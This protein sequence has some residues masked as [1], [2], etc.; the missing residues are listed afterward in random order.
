MQLADK[1]HPVA[2]PAVDHQGNIYVTFSGP[3][4]QHVP[5]S[6][7][8][9]TANYDVKPFLTSL[10]NPTGL[11]LDREG[12]LFV[13]CRNDGTL[14]RAT[15]EGRSEPWIEGMRIATGSACDRAASLY[16]GARSGTIFTCSPAREI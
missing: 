13:S 11:A 1:R 16:V 9:I 2:N 5:V 7:Y 10:V 15:P 4:G 12:S 3:R 8:K 6:L 14:H